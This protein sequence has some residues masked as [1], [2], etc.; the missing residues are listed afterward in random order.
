[1]AHE[2]LEC[3]VAVEGFKLV[4]KRSSRVWL[5]ESELTDKLKRNRNLKTADI[6]DKKL[7][8]PAQMEKMFFK[9]NLDPEILSAYTAHVGSGTTV[10][11]SSD[12]RPDAS[13]MTA[14][15]ALADFLK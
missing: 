5:S 7:K 3:G 15:R 10:A 11:K 4:N 13:P 1:M 8:S 14:L 9:K 6:F 2:Q 12:K